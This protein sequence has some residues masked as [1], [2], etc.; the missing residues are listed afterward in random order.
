MSDDGNVLFLFPLEFNNSIHMITA[1]K[2]SLLHTVIR[3]DI[4]SW[5]EVGSY[6]F[7]FFYDPMSPLMTVLVKLS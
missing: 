7:L 3:G 1:L 2:I 6:T 4:G 5:C